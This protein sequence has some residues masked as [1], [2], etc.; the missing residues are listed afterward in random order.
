[1]NS[2]RY[3]LK[4]LVPDYLRAGFGFFVPVGLML[5]TD[6][7]P[8]VFYV[9]AGLALLFGIYGL[10]TALRQA[11]V[12]SVDGNGL[13]QEGPLG[14]VF[15]R[16]L[17]WADMRDFRLRYFSTRRDHKQ[18]WM[19]L[20]LRAA[21]DSTSHGPIRL[22]SD[23]HGFDDIVRMAYDVSERRGLPVD[24]TSASNLAAMGLGDGEPHG[25]SHDA[26]ITS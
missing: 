9:L 3:P 22:D 16:Y 10:R 24:P 14:A 21:D 2:Y 4:E 15:D 17:C 13:R 20:I 18:G 12:L 5:F 7:A 6:L 23:L 19:Q 11:T 8:L 1:M 26:A 25:R